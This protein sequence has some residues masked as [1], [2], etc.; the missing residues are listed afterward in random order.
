MQ[1]KKLFDTS[2]ELFDFKY[3]KRESFYIYL[4]EYDISNNLKI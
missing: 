3:V 2:K 4:Q 1:K